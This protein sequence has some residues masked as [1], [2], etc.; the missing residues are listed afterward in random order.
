[1]SR[2]LFLSLCC[3]CLL[4][5]S[6]APPARSATAR[7][8]GGVS[9]TDRDCQSDLQCTFVDD[10][11]SGQCSA[12]CSSTPSCQERFGDESMCLGADM[13]ARTCGNDLACP[14]GS[15]CNAYGWCEAAER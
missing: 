5:I 6:A 14:G 2:W 7:P 3:T 10:V 1:M 9:A 11:L 4:A 8:L 13:C 12:T 15:T